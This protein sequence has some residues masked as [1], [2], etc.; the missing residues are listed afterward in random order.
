MVGILIIVW[1]MYRAQRDK[2]FKEFNL[3]DLLMEHGRLSR[4]ACVFLGSFLTT[5]WIM[6]RLTLDG[7]MTEG[8][9][10]GYGA[11][12]VAPIVA[13]ILGPSTENKPNENAHPIT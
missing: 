1:T 3:F 12:W 10:A 11:L 13:K 9:L 7:K 2:K 5:S 6:V 4:I 8:Y